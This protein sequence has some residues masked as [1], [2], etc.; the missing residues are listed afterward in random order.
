M[1]SVQYRV[2]RMRSAYNAH[3]F[4]CSLG[5]SC[6][7]GILWREQKNSLEGMYLNCEER[8]QTESRFDRKC[9]GHDGGSDLVVWFIYFVIICMPNEWAN[10]ISVV[11]YI[12]L[13]LSHYKANM[14]RLSKSKKVSFCCLSF[15]C[16]FHFLVVLLLFFDSN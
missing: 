8:R 12:C 14:D 1:D 6:Q 7:A 5:R 10:Q 11:I 3:K 4:H 16:C 13:L 9:Y 15:F 2:H